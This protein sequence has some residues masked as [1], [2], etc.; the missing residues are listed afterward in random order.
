[1]DHLPPPTPPTDSPSDIIPEDIEEY[2]GRDLTTSQQLVSPTS[3]RSLGEA[4]DERD[5][6]Y[7]AA[8]SPPMEADGIFRAACTQGA[9]GEGMLMAS[10]LGNRS[11]FQLFTADTPD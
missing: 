10:H 4:Q 8:T 1:M 5:G 7:F 6:R 2:P 11:L 3:I 9:V